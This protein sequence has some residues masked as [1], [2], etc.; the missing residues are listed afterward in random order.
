L[1]IEPRQAP[2][3]RLRGHAWV[4]AGA[5][6]CEAPQPE[7]LAKTKRFYAYPADDDA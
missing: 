1:L 7:L 4:S 5:E 3:D 2:G 6:F